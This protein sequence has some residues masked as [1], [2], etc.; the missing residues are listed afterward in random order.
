M[1]ESGRG[2]IWV[3]IQEYVSGD[4]KTPRNLNQNN[5]C[6]GLESNWHL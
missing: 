2:L 1:E 6:S 3:T 5:L 4:W